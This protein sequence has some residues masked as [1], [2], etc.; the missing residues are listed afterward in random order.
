[1]GGGGI[2]TS[3]TLELNQ[4]TVSRNSAPN[5]AGI[6]A[7]FGSDTTILRSALVENIGRPFCRGSSCFAITGIGILAASTLTIADSTISHN[8]TS[9]PV[10]AFGGGMFII[11][12]NAR[13][14]I[15]QTVIGFNNVAATDG[16]GG[17]A[18]GAVDTTAVDVKGSATF[19]DVYVIN[20]VAGA[21]NVGGLELDVG[22]IKLVNM[23]I[24]DNSGIN[25]RGSACP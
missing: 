24:K 15:D 23:T 5:G 9:A 7:S 13:M 4:V 16:S 3:G 6:S 21:K 18:G 19:S 2:F 20:N 22:T 10:G 14:N 25:C 17:G 8:I 11:Q 12:T 1:M